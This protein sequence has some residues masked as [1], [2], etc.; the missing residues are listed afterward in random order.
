MINRGGDA[1]LVYS[2]ARAESTGMGLT[3]YGSECS[4]QYSVANGIRAGLLTNSRSAPE[5]LNN[6]RNEM[7]IKTLVAMIGAALPCYC[8]P[9]SETPKP[10]ALDDAGA[11]KNSLI[12]I[13]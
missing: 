10:N 11:K 2:A 3:P 13:F 7:K 5:I 1:T 12:Q 4:T 8:L 9:A 6:N